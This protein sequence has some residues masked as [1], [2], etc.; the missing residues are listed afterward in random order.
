MRPSFEP[1]VPA[2]QPTLPRQA[3]GVN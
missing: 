1:L 2:Y 3:S